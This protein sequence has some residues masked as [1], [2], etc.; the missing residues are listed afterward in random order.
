MIRDEDVIKSNTGK[1]M[2]PHEKVFYSI[3]LVFGILLAIAGI[4]LVILGEDLLIW[5]LVLLAVGIA[6]AIGVGLL[7]WTEGVKKDKK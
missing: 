5:G 4:V 2:K 1:Y 3:A 6:E 7:L